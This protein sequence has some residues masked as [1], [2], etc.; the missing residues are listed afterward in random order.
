[1][2]DDRADFAHHQDIKISKKKRNE[3]S[4]KHLPLVKQRNLNVLNFKNCKSFK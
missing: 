3:K 4:P 1:V 2:L